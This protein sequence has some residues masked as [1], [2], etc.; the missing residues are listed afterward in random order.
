MLNNILRLERD[1]VNESKK[2][3]SGSGVHKIEEQLSSY[4]HAVLSAHKSSGGNAIF[5][6]VEFF[7][8]HTLL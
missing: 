2:D 4:L 8:I 6:S 3:Q 7:T 1:V 5:I